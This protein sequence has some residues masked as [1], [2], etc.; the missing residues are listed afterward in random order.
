MPSSRV[1]RLVL[2]LFVAAMVAA[3]VHAAPLPAAPLAAAPLPAGMVKGPSVE[4][5]TEYDCANG[6]RVLL[7]PDATTENVTV[8]INYLV[9]SR[10]ENYGEGGM[11]HLFEHLMFRTAAGHRDIKGELMQHG[12]Q[13]NGTTSID[14]TN[15]FETVTASDANLA[16][17][18][19]LEASRMARL[20]IG[21]ADLDAER[22]IVQNEMD[23]GENDGGRL[24]W[25]ALMHA[26]YQWHNYG[27]ST[28]GLRSDLDGV[29]LERVQAF[30][31]NYYQPDNAVL[32]VAG[33]LDVAKTLALV[34]AKFGVLPAPT[35]RLYP[36]YTVEPTQYGE[37]QVTMR[38]AGPRPSVIAAYHIPAG[39][40]PDF[41]A[42][43]VLASALGNPASGRLN[44]ALV[45]TNQAVDAS[46]GCLRQ[47]DAGLFLVD[48][49]APVNAP[50]E[51]L[52]DSLTALAEGLPAKPIDAAEVDRAKSGMAKR[53]EMAMLNS[54][55]MATSL[56]EWV[57]LGDWRLFF[58]HRDRI[59]AVTL[60][61]VQRVAATYLKPSN[62][63]VGLFYP[64]TNGDRVTIP[65]TPDIAAAVRDYKG[66]AAVAEG[67]TFDPTPANLD[68]R[69][70]WGQT[71]SGLK[72][73][74]LPR[75]TRGAEVSVRI[76]LRFGDLESVKGRLAAADM[77]GQLLMR[78]SAKYTRQQI[79]D[80]INR[81]K[82]EV[83]VGGNATSAS[84][85]VRTTRENLVAAL[86]FAVEVLRTPTFPA[87]E[88]AEARTQSLAATEESKS[89][90]RAQLGVALGRALNVYPPGDPRYVQTPEEAAADLQ[91]LTLEAVKAFYTEFYGAS[92]GEVAACGDFDAA[93]LTA[94]TEKLLGGW[95]SGKPYTR[96]ARPFVAAKPQRLLVRMADKP[97]GTYQTVNLLQVRDDDP[98]YAAGLLAARLLGGGA[99]SR[100]WKR[101]REKEGIS[102]GISASFAAGSQDD[103][104]S[105]A[106]GGIF[107]AKDLAKF[108]AAVNDE[109]QR[110]L[111]DGFTAEEVAAAKDAVLRQRRSARAADSGL[112]GRLGDLA[113]LGRRF[114][115]D[116]ALDD[117]VAAL[118]PAQ[119]NAALRRFCQPEAQ[120]VGVAGDLP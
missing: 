21:R 55:R 109:V 94:L 47:H 89:D 107:P 114:A 57:G 84:I 35:R 14:R 51:P 96:I 75:K 116:A 25:F 53:T 71:P 112:A 38:V 111:K 37:R 39:S 81:L 86:S 82:A 60:A 48:A 90:P 66:R 64:T 92:T 5:I 19:D 70:Q 120:V 34:A 100:L 69:T 95:K 104:G 41:A 1:C 45:K 118:T 108:E 85:N 77:A 56:S 110:A 103:R 43:D 101:V 115:W 62:R 88:F 83:S 93:E 6:L 9:G 12:A 78:G 52:R 18:L 50:L 80:E 46:A 32:V 106:I 29:P 102:Y 42:L 73:A 54:Q 13:W 30:Y 36:T 24:L 4:G 72:L 105:F 40:H 76:A 2:G 91:G 99:D 117:K 8:C 10:F 3:G 23:S 22:K 65:P 11:A 20:T 7:F 26:A 67:E 16:W 15:F 44:E 97:N 31:R 58:L 33:K 119:I 98:D 74:L 61:D 17:A 49:D 113:Y 68:A 63:T 27:R 87:S 28:I 79:Q 59:A